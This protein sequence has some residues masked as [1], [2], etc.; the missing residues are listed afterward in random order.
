MRSDKPIGFFLSGGVDSTSLCYL[1]KKELGKN[2]SSFSV[3]GNDE[4]YDESI[5]RAELS[6]LC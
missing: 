2:V 6:T 4:R 3:G 1:A 5:A